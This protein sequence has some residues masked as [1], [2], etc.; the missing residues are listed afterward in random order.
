MHA[1]NCTDAIKKERAIFGRL[2]ITPA[3]TEAEI[4]KL[5]EIIPDCIRARRM[6]GVW[7]ALREM[8]D[9]DIEVSGRLILARK[10]GKTILRIR[11]VRPVIDARKV[12]TMILDATL[13]AKSILQ[14]LFPQVE[15]VSDVEVR[16]PH[17]HVRQVVNAPVSQN[18]LWGT[19]Q[20]PS[21][22]HN[23]H[24]VRRYILRRWIEIDGPR[25]WAEEC[26]R[27]PDPKLRRKPVVVICQKEVRLWLANAET[28]HR[29][30][31]KVPRPGVALPEGIALE[32]FNA[33]AGLDDH[34]HVALLMTIGRTLPPPAA[35][36]AIAGALSGAQPALEAPTGRG[37]GKVPRAIRMADGTGREVEGCSQHVDPLAEAVRYQI[38]EAEL[39]QSIGRGRGVNRTASTPLEVDIVGDEVLPVSVDQVAQW[40]EPSEMVEP[41]ALDGLVLI[42]QGDMAKGWPSLWKTA[43][44]AKWTLKKLR[45][46]TEG[47]IPIR[48]IPN[49]DSPFCAELE[50]P[51]ARART[52]VE[53]LIGKCRSVLALYQRP[54]ERQKLREVIFDPRQVPNLR[55]KLTEKLGGMFAAILHY[56]RRHEIGRPL[57]GAG[58]VDIND[59]LVWTLVRETLDQLFDRAAKHPWRKLPEKQPTPQ[60]VCDDGSQPLPCPQRH[61]RMRYK[62][63]A[64]PAARYTLSDNLHPTYTGTGAPGRFALS[65]DPQS[66]VAHD[67]RPGGITTPHEK[68]PL[69]LRLYALGLHE[70]NCNSSE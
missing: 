24:A 49:R 48:D 37:Y 70:T 66:M 20:E 44:H 11:G 6:V 50:S 30:Y 55:E 41:L 40:E 12:P 21:K 18:K 58:K 25:L 35:V 32:H 26:Q 16:M 10:D 3:M 38:C 43:E 8:L 34:K 52:A 28:D 56:L 9:S 33:I 64:Q 42:T 68:L 31:G 29:W 51:A 63:V 67:G 15:V 19:E 57:A 45:A 23:L 7:G 14:K 22:G 17:V 1:E 60:F 59:G 61:N 27:E 69:E 39:I 36:E 53:T 13:P 54:G 46:S 62:T 2:K 47:R 4:D 65:T 5:Q